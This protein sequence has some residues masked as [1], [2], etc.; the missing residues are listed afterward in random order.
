M[1]LRWCVRRAWYLITTTK[2]RRAEHFAESQR[3]FREAFML[4]KG[5]LIEQ[6][7]EPAPKETE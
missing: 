7:A 4:Y 2:A 3:R 6:S 5:H 1:R